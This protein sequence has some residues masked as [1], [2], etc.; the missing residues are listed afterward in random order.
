MK[1]FDFPFVSAEM[2]PTFTR[3][4]APNKGSE[5]TPRSRLKQNAKKS[6]TEN[7]TNSPP[8]K[9]AAKVR[10]KIKIQIAENFTKNSQNRLYFSKT[11]FNFVL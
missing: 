7:S 8:R 10:Q 4:F 9:T 5:S 2:H 1:I 6:L 11:A 3:R